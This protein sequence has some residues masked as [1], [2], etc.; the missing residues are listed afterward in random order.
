[1]QDEEG[2]AQEVV[3][4]PLMN[5]R[6]LISGSDSGIYLVLDPISVF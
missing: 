1:M 3:D 5:T 2:R 4:H 6:T